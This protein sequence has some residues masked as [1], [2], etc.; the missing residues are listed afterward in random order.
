MR[1]VPNADLGAA[2]RV[3]AGEIAGSPQETGIEA[4]HDGPE[5]APEGCRPTAGEPA[6]STHGGAQDQAVLASGI[7]RR[8]RRAAAFAG[9]SQSASG[10]GGA[11]EKL[12]IR[13]ASGAATEATLP[14]A[15]TAPTP[16]DLLATTVGAA[17]NAIADTAVLERLNIS[18]T[19]WVDPD[20]ARN[21]AERPADLL[22]AVAMHRH[23]VV[24]DEFATSLDP[25]L[26]VDEA[27]LDE[28]AVL[29]DRL[30]RQL[31]ATGTQQTT[32]TLSAMRAVF[33]HALRADYSKRRQL[34]ALFAPSESLG[35]RTP[36]FDGF[37]LRNA[38][39]KSFD[40][41]LDGKALWAAPVLTDLT[42]AGR[43]ALLTEKFDEMAESV[44]F[45]IGSIPHSL[46]T[47]LLRLERYR[48]KP[49]PTPDDEAAL[50]RAFVQNEASWNDGA[51]YP[52]HPRLLFAMHLA[53]SSG[54]E[55]DSP[56]QLRL[57]YENQI[58]DE[59]L[60]QLAS[61]NAAPAEWIAQ[62]LSG[63]EGRGVRW[64]VAAPAQQAEV[65]LGLFDALR[66]QADRADQADQAGPIATFARA[67][68]AKGVLTPN[69]IVG[70]DFNARAQA[71]L[72]YANE[73]LLAAYGEPP[74]FDRREAA[75]DI[76]RR[77][78]IDE[79]AMTD[80]RHYVIVGDNPNVTKTAFGD[81]IDEFLDRADWVGLN[82]ASMTPRAGIS[83]KPRAEL[84]REEE[85][86][87]ARLRTDPWV[88]AIA[89]ERLREQEKETT[90][91]EVR[92]VAEEIAGNF[93]TETESHRALVR[94][95]D[96]WV[97][98]VPVI[99]PLYNIEEGVRHKDAT[100]AAFG[101]LFLGVDGFDLATGA[102][103]ARSEA[104]HPVVPKLRRALGH[105]D[106]STSN[107]AGHAEMIEMQVDP[108]RIAKPDAQVPDEL[109][110]LTRQAREGKSVRWR[111][112]DIVHL[113]DEDR[114]VPVRRE[115]EAY[116]E[117]DWRTGHRLR[118]LPDIEL[119]ARAGKG[120]RQHASARRGQREPGVR[121][122]EVRERLTVDRVADLI[123]HA[124]DLK[125]RDFDG[126]FA[127]AFSL[128][129]PPANS[130]Q[131]G[132][133]AFY[134]K[135]YKSSDTFRRLFNRHAHLDARARNGTAAVWKKWEFVIGEGGPLGAPNKAYT[136]FDHKRI[137][138]PRDAAIEAMPYMSAA[139]PQT[140]TREQAYLHEMIH[141]LTGARDP[142]RMLDMMNRGPV[143]YL[144]DKILS[145]AGYA[146]P[147]Q[148]MYRRANS[149]SDMPV[150]QTVE[151]HAD[152]AARSAALE[153]R[154]LDT[155][156]D[157]KRRPLSA[158]TLVE[159]VPVSS[160][161]TVAR[162]QEVLSA[163]EDEDD[164]V[165]LAWSDFRTKFDQNFGFYV[166]DRNMT[167]ALASDAM[168]VIDFYGRLY[169]R[170]VTFRRMFDKMPVTD[171]TRADPWK[172]VLE[173]D[174]EFDLLS[175]GGRAH[176]VSAEA[177]KIYVLD[178]GL[179]Y[180]SEYGLREVELERQLAY[181]MI[182]AITGLP[183]MPAPDALANRGAAVLLTDRILR[184]AGF[185]YPPQLVAALVEPGDAMAQ[186]RLL[187]H[188]TQALRSAAA[189]DRYLLL[190]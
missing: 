52:Y 30:Q 81:L 35:Q 179:Q 131:F 145:E 29:Y 188:Q 184:E 103:G 171:A 98:T 21:Y 122:D 70:V 144:T 170:S 114:I 75:A 4:G 89:K 105:I 160:R 48:G 137:Y 76:L 65:L 47:S 175:P 9:A 62:Y 133:R 54:F 108:V 19:E 1:I 147:E 11:P 25:S 6:Q 123:G 117:L 116:V 140:L 100:R 86:F 92:R 182:C 45:P 119:D 169:Q 124:N 22:R 189:E 69:R 157:A 84:Q 115:G 166:Q 2:L 32:P 129:P 49:L 102:G 50:A 40:D 113:G 55:V 135:L 183:K 176:G 56:D 63:W 28:G 180:L 73:R 134:R 162:T 17:R 78:G 152:A 187:S 190:G 106:S 94:G 155:L 146:I 150:D 128:T 161:R 10:E 39:G 88:V 168:V 31:P 118:D 93:A 79:D 33:V 34:D 41:L 143:V 153:N 67:L 18:L 87:N 172:F 8:L 43:R 82:G 44:R 132:A 178:D 101:L 37:A 51:D 20:K 59:A 23:R 110:A 112:Y 156:V 99:G 141:A 14:A 148:I 139:G 42:R 95:L 107:M 77:H 27:L 96:T 158:D 72:Q 36:Y 121:G 149:T 120:W 5:R 97:N 13:F 15:S 185:H 130:S 163:I 90:V 71:V 126:L 3:N 111:N 24:P 127:E 61:G 83:I 174:I 173:G 177:K 167:T 91:D 164:E 142:E 68:R 181:Q 165:F 58:S 26:L 159:G 53:R 151:Y 16:S 80:P 138:M 64:K 7:E 46:A 57:L 85:A 12:S 38:E 154:Y 104:V 125:Q 74:R 60:E 186:A 109:R 66:A 136:D